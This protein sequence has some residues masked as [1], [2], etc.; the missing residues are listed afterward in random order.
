ML[1]AGKRKTEI[2]KGGMLN[3]TTTCT[4][5]HYSILHAAHRPLPASQLHLAFVS[6]WKCVYGMYPLRVRSR[7][8]RVTASHNQGSVIRNT[9]TYSYIIS[10]RLHGMAFFSYISVS[11][12]CF[13]EIVRKF[14]SRVG[15][16]A[17]KMGGGGTIMIPAKGYD[18]SWMT[19][20]T[21][22]HPSPHSLQGPVHSTLNR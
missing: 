21:V 5:T 13:T 7:T 6:V 11:K 1:S 9:C 22:Q 14:P 3:H 16:N 15:P 18:F 2:C 4:R 19:V 8:V 17:R 20:S 10:H 12:L